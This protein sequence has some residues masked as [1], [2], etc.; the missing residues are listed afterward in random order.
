MLND[1]K[2]NGEISGSIPLC[3]DSSLSVHSLDD[4]YKPRLFQ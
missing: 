3:P 2:N 4:Y 1:P